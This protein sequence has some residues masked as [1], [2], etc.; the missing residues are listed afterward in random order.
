MMEPSPIRVLSVD[1]HPLL[2]EGISAMITSQPDMV[3]VAAA[4]TG[5]DGIAQFREHRPDVTLMDLRLPDMNGIEATRRIKAAHPAVLVVLISTGDPGQLPTAV[6][7]CD[8]AA[9]ARKQ[10]LNPRFLRELWQALQ[11]S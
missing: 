10:D 11:S 1:D 2:R 3:L 7:E 6:H 8:A 9:V 4:S 5:R